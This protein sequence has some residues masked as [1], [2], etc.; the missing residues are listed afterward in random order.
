[1]SYDYY[2]QGNPSQVLY[3]VVNLNGRIYVANKGDGLKLLNDEFA[4]YAPVEIKLSKH[5]ND[6][7]HTLEITVYDASDE[8]FTFLD[9][10][11]GETLGKPFLIYSEFLGELQEPQIEIM[12]EV[13]Q[14]SFKE[15]GAVIKC[16]SPQLNRSRTGVTYN[17]Q[18]FKTL[19]GYL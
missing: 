19:K 13:T 16:Q 3:Q 18:D 2:L 5:K 10:D 4:E 9:T 15:G 14:I 11:F 12:F 17:T 8:T 6:L 1:M 7:E